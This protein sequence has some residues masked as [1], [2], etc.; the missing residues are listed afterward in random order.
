VLQV[1]GAKA[2]ADSSGPQWDEYELSCRL[3][4][5]VAVRVRDRSRKRKVSPMHYYLAVFHVLLARLAEASDSAD[6]AIGLADTNCQ[7][8]VDQSTMGFFANML[9]I[10]LGCAPDQVFNEIL[11]ELK[12]QVRAALVHS[13]MPYMA[14]LDRLGLRSPD[15]NDGASHA[16][17]FQAVFG[18]KQG[19]TESGTIDE[20]SII[21]YRT[22]RAG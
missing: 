7:T 12:E 14:I 17:L 1:P 22:P 4:R 20:A 15:Q 13:S 11:S 18:Y 19:Q 5:M 8:L 10:R 9:P 2:V 21:E 3:N 6:I 16:P